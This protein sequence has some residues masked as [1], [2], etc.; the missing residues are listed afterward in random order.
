MRIPLP[1]PGKAPLPLDD[2]LPV[3]LVRRVVWA[4]EE[5]PVPELL[6]LAMDALLR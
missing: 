3:M 5:N 2:K 6:K 1:W 4:D